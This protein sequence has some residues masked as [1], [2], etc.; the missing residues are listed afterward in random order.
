[1]QNITAGSL[2]GLLSLAL[3]ASA[4]GSHDRDIFDNQAPTSDAFGTAPSTSPA[5][6]EANDL[7]S[8]VGCEYYAVHMDGL[9]GADNGC[10]VAFVAN[11]QPAPVKLD[12]SFA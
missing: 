8:S 12:V 3:T 6:V 9:F 4:C 10:F 5:C 7:R 11:A 2:L 1:M